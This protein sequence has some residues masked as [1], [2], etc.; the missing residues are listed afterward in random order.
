MGA[1]LDPARVEPRSG[2]RKAHFLNDTPALV[3]RTTVK[4]PLQIIPPNPYTTGTWMADIHV[5]D[6][7]AE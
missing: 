7:A 5:L 2:T 3:T 6:V 1:Q 4:L